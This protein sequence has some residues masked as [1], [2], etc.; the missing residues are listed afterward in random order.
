[1][2]AP[3]AYANPEPSIAA[4]YVG[5]QPT[6]HDDCLIGTLKTILKTDAKTDVGV[7]FCSLSKQDFK[8][9]C[10][11]IVGMWIKAFLYPNKQELVKRMCEGA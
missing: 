2:L 3:F 9:A 6:Y 7:K 5:N 1:M 8:A 4:C 10:Y 11:E